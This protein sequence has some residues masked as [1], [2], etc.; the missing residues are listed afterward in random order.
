[1]TA[2]LGGAPA[3]ALPD[4]AYP[5]EAEAPPAARGGVTH[6]VRPRTGELR[7]RVLGPDGSPPPAAEIEI[8]H[9][10][11]PDSRA[12]EFRG[13]TLAQTSG[14]DGDVVATVGLGLRL[15]VVARSRLRGDGHAICDGPIA[16]GSPA[17][18]VVRLSDEPVVLRA[19]LLLP[20]GAPHAGAA[21]RLHRPYDPETPR[22]LRSLLNLEATTDA[23]GRAKFTL[24]RGRFDVAFARAVFRTVGPM[25]TRLVGEATLVADALGGGFDAGDVALAADAPLVAG[26]VI[27]DAGASVQDAVVRAWCPPVKLDPQTAA[28]DVQF[29]DLHRRLIDVECDA[30]NGAFAAYGP[31]GPWPVTVTASAPGYS[32]EGRAVGEPGARD[33]LVRV[34]GS[35]GELEGTTR[36]GS[37]PPSDFS[38]SFFRADSPAPAPVAEATLEADGSFRSGPLAVGR[39]DVALRYGKPH[40]GAAHGPRVTGV[41]VEPGRTSSDPRLRPLPFGA[42]VRRVRLTV[43]DEAGNPA[44]SAAALPLV[45]A[46]GASAAESFAAPHATADARGEI[47]LYVSAA[48]RDVR[49]FDAD[50]VRPLLQSVVLRGVI[51]DRRVVLP[52]RPRLRV[53]VAGGD[54]ATAGASLRASLAD[55]HD[56]ECFGSPFDDPEIVR[57]PEPGEY[58]IR[59]TLAKTTASEG[60]IVS[61]PRPAAP[62]RVTV[63]ASPGEQRI[64]ATPPPEILE[65]ARRKLAETGR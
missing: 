40:S 58:E 32:R 34:G 41:A 2:A 22:K 53:V 46:P 1:L 42:D 59:W 60:M 37:Y 13:A 21:V 54:L 35:T 29:A 24:D 49:V 30:R 6:L 44:A 50:P 7:V 57:P 38:V 3:G 43:V 45:G 12:P 17:E 28:D 33:L 8:S 5:Y 62:Q 63:A 23:D 16:E 27:D 25:G 15:K 11:P 18:V 64:T 51:E 48:S 61:L 26:R 9:A 20:G 19:R 56:H 52:Q 14:S 10:S 31:P 4:L 39:Y 47:V 36:L 65:A 55:A